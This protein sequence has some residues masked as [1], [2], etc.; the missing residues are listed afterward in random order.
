MWLYGSCVY[1]VWEVFKMATNEHDEGVLAAEAFLRK[2]GFVIKELIDIEDSRPDVYAEKKTGETH[3]KAIVEVETAESIYE[4][5]SAEQMID[6]AAWA[7]MN[8]TRRLILF[9]PKGRKQ[10]AKKELP[11][12]KEYV[13]F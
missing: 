8:T 3:T 4:T 13:E 9:I 2:E 11:S 10:E 5:Q 12:Y 1:Q 6:F 7:K